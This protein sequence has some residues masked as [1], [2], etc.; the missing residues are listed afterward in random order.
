MYVPLDVCD[1]R[2]FGFGCFLELPHVTKRKRGF[3]DK[4]GKGRRG[5]D[6]EHALFFLRRASATIE[7]QGEGGGGG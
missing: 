4:N 2:T 3:G 7:D 1:L 5:D 6:G